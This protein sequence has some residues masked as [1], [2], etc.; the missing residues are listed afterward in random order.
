MVAVY[1]STGKEVGGVQ[2]FRGVVR[3]MAYSP[4]GRKLITGMDD[5]TALIWNVTDAMK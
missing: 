5:S 4:D 3:S 1:R 2:G